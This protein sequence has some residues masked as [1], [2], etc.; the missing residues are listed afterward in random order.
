[1]VTFK[2]DRPDNK[3][4]ILKKLAMSLLFWVLVSVCFFFL[5]MFPA[6]YFGAF[7]LLLQWLIDTAAI[8]RLR[9]IS[10]D[11]EA[12]QVIF[13]HKTFLGS[14][15]EKRLPFNRAVLEVR[16]TKPANSGSR[17]YMVL[18]FLNSENLFFEISN[19]KDG[20]SADTLR[21][22]YWTVELIPL[23]IK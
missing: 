10:F 22:I 6:I 18:R 23:P 4:Y 7:F 19:N 13:L 20:F 16:N 12:G 17:K 1:M 14:P 15:A 2:T 11:T 5:F 21:K 8:A 9:K 3:M